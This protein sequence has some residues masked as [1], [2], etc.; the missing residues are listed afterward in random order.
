MVVA[1]A[2]AAIVVV[3]VVVVVA[4]VRD[5]KELVERVEGDFVPHW[6]IS[7]PLVVE[8]PKE[9]VRSPTSSHRHDHND[10]DDDDDD[11]DDIDQPRRRW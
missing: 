4:V 10:D 11:D 1:A 6:F 5:E 8:G 2:A 7:N 9:T 3:V